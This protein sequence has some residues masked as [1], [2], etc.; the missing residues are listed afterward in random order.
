MHLS[1]FRSTRGRIERIVR[2]LDLP[3]DWTAE[4]FLAAVEG[5]R[6]RPIRRLALPA[7]EEVPQLCG[8]WFECPS[9]DL[10]LHRP[11]AQREREQFI[12]AH[13]VGHILVD[14]EGGT[15]LDLNPS[16]LAASLTGMDL[17]THGIDVGQVAAARGGGYERRSEYEAELFATLVMA[18]ARPESVSPPR[19]RFLRIF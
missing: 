1:R 14:P 3:A 10:I 8:L 16:E 2:K 4:E 7:N 9:F 12:V 15:T 13:E 11:S 18:K 17:A 19:E 6:N 5:Y